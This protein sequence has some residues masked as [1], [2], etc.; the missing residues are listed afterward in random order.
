MKFGALTNDVAIDLGT[1][2]TGIFYKGN[3]TVRPSVIAFDAD[4]GKVIA[5]GDEAAEMIGR[6]PEAVTVAKPLANGVVTDFDQTCEMIRGFLAQVIGNGVIKPRVMVT[7]PCGATDVEKKAVR[8]A[9]MAADIKDVY[10]MEAPIAGAIGANCD[11][12]LARGMMLIDI[13]GGSCD[14]AAISLGQVVIGRSLKVAG[15]EFT[16]AIIDYTQRKYDLLIGEHTAAKIKEEIGCAFQREKDESIEI[17]GFNTKTRSLQKIRISSEE[18]REAFAPLLEEIVAEIKS[19]L[20]ET[21]TELLGDIMEDGILLVGGGAQ[22]YGLP[23]KLRIEL[24]VKVFLAEDAQLCVV[25]GAGA[26]V[27]NMDKMSDNS[28]LFYKG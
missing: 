6:N 14:I 12:S 9:V 27:E 15:N 16:N 17:G 25:R 28:Y 10:I 22:L 20:D 23:T 2:N 13:G 1:D 21:P 26:T 7:V 11:V 5:L 19:A 8:D 24:G 4:S 3:V 18:T